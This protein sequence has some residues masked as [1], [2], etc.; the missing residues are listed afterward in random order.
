M[1][2]G[3]GCTSMQVIDPAQIIPAQ[4]PPYVY[5]QKSNGEVLDLLKP[6]IKGDLL[7]GTRA[8][9]GEPFSVPL[10]DITW[11]KAKEH[12]KTRTLVATVGGVAV[13]SAILIG[14]A[15]QSG[16]HVGQPCS[17]IAQQNNQCVGAGQ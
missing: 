8:Q 2:A 14:L 1:L 13:G 7:T 12:D 15:S 6:V 9:T 4:N 5:L 11:V 16:S 3:V 17:F 10:K